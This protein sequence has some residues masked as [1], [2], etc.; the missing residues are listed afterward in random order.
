MIQTNLHSQLKAFPLQHFVTHRGLLVSH[1]LPGEP[2]ITILDKV[3]SSQALI[4]FQQQTDYDKWGAFVDTCKLLS[5]MKAGICDTSQSIDSVSG[6]FS[7]VMASTVVVCQVLQCIVYVSVCFL[8]F[9]KQ[10]NLDETHDCCES[11]DRLCLI[12]FWLCA[13]ESD[14]HHNG[15]MALMKFR[16]KVSK[17]QYILYIYYSFLYFFQVLVYAIHFTIDTAMI[18]CSRCH[19]DRVVMT[20]C[21]LRLLELL[22]MLPTKVIY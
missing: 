5:V 6:L 10:Q 3:S 4:R 16:V 18:K 9:I 17:L 14:M 7:S 2:S 20:I 15:R 13:L 8:F 1:P 19:G 22:A 12:V 21:G 11:R